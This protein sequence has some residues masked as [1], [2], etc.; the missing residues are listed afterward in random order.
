MFTI[1]FHGTLKDRIQITSKVI[2][3]QYLLTSCLQAISFFE[4]NPLLIKLF[5]NKC[6]VPINLVLWQLMYRLKSS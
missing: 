1:G 2:E 6:S 4:L 5:F 3:R